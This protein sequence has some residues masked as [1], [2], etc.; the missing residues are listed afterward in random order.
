MATE[1]PKAADVLDPRTLLRVLTALKKGD[2]TVRMPEDHTGLAGKIADCLND[3]IDLNERLAKE[4]ARVSIAVA[5]KAGSPSGR[6]CPG[7]RARGAS[8]SSR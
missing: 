3:V 8:A 4:L 2:F 5:A 6:R 7:P 1:S